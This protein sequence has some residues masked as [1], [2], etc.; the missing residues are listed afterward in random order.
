[1]AD[2]II[3]PGLDRQ[4]L[5]RDY[6]PSTLV[7]DI[8]VY[9]DDYAARSARARRDHPSHHILRYGPAPAA[10][11]DFFPATVPQAPLHVFV[12]GGYW[13]ELGPEESSFAAPG[14]TAAGAAFAAVGYGLAPSYRLADITSMVRLALVWLSRQAEGLGV[15]PLRIV[16]SGSSAGAH[17]VLMALCLEP[18]LRQQIAAAALLSG[19]YDLRPLTRTYVNDA[20]GLT[21]E[22]AVRN[23]PLFRLP[24]QLPP[25]ILARGGGETS[26]FIR[27]H[28]TLRAALLDRGP[29]TEVVSAERNHFD[30]PFELPDPR[31]AL[32]QAVLAAMGLPI[33][34]PGRPA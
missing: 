27:Q 11:I 22:A 3:G 8:Q 34:D 14:F 30:L 9:L 20:L 28:E 12:H 26:A 13:Q 21:H 29:V 4:A 24:D 23:S 17:L 2:P 33:A 16:V 32:G 18:V 31:T 1:M 19:V 25:I 15:D 5:D 10:T 7:T 6:S